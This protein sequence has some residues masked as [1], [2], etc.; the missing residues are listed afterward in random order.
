MA[1]S[2]Q[3]RRNALTSLSER[4]P[5]VLVI[6][7]GVVGCS[8]AAHA[9]A[10]G[11]QTA[12]VE[13]G[14]FAVGASGNSTG[15]A[16][17]G[18]RYLAQGQLSYVFQECRERLRLEALAPH[19]VRPF[20]FIYPVYKGDAHGL[21]ALRVGTAL[22]DVFYRLASI[23]LPKRPGRRFR[24]L[25]KALVL[26]RIRTL[27]E[28]NL[29][30][31]TQYFVDARLLD[32][33]FTLGFAQV[34]AAKGARVATYTRVERIQTASGRVTDVTLLDT[35]THKEITVKPQLVINATGA[36][37]DQL[38]AKVELSE[39][40]LQNSKGIHLLVDQ[41]SD[42]PLILSSSV[43]GKV[44]FV[45]PVGRYLS[46]VG[47]TDTAYSESPDETKASVTDVQSLLDELFR[48][49]PGLQ[50]P[51]ESIN[52]AQ[53][54]YRKDHVK[55]VYWGLRPLVR[56]GART[57]DAS[58]DYRLVKELGNF[59]SVPGVK[60]TAGRKAGDEVAAQAA[61]FLK[62]PAFKAGP[63]GPLPG[64][65]FS[66]FAAF[67][68]EFQHR[69]DVRKWSGD[70]I[71]Y[72]V[73]LYGTHA[74]E[75]LEYARADKALQAPVHPDEPWIFAEARYAVER[76]MVLSLNDFVWRRTRWARLRDLPEDSLHCIADIL[77]EALKWSPEERQ[78]QLAAYQLERNKHTLA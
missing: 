10:Q 50:Q 16:H 73:T 27:Q 77:G 55:R 72:L 21:L 58:R 39:P 9:A 78:R 54:R 37:I 7:G 76:E 14:D 31:A 17:A 62:K 48:F 25:S 34:A 11:L 41:I 61:H 46:L 40:L 43:P 38:R 2:W 44:F 19:W 65:E 75:V 47:T 6:G 53:A 24:V 22:Y 74:A 26:E 29:K 69:A 68:G 23:G 56:S 28:K 35:L 51:E 42:T 64:G 13:A 52:D 67:L 32:S 4:S 30:G 45:I 63:I 49:F 66:D 71:A 5:E 33:R 59:W 60:L 18:I 12:L 15:L 57:V 3:E 36:W 20:S 8:I 1:F 70:T